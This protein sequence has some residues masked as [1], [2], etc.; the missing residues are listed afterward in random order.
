M[1]E[2]SSEGSITGVLTVVGVERGGPFDESA[3]L[4]LSSF[5]TQ[6]RQNLGASGARG[7]G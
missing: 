3:L 5:S 4:T 1:R 6:A 2:E 7:G